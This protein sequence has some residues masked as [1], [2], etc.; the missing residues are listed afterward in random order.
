MPFRDAYRQ[1]A[2][3]LKEGTFSPDPETFKSTHTGG[4]ANLGL[5]ACAAD[6]AQARGWI[7]AQTEHVT[8]AQ[9]GIW[10]VT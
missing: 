7:E 4:T 9:H 3:E 2:Q 8:L 5:E 6:L 1:V 10:D